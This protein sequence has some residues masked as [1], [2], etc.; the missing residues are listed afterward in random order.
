[1]AKL[2][3][4]QNAGTLEN[5]CVGTG[6]LYVTVYGERVARAVRI[7][8]KK[9]ALDAS[10]FP[11]LMCVDEIITEKKPVNIH[12]YPRVNYKKEVPKNSFGVFR[13]L[14]FI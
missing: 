10:D 8:A 3:A 13:H 2:L 9:G 14:L 6:D 1:M 7:A 5:L 4:Y 11:L 12:I